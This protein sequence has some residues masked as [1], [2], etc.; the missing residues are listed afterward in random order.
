MTSSEELHAMYNAVAN[1][2]LV[3]PFDA[4]ISSGDTYTL[5]L[6]N[7]GFHL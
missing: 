4:D 1:V 5:K 6:Q 7:R 2:T 3:A